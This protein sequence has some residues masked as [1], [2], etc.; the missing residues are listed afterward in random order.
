MGYKQR[1]CP[2][3]NSD[4]HRGDAKQVTCSR[5]C[6]QRLR[7][8]RSGKL[9][10]MRRVCEVCGD[11]Y[12]YSYS[13]QRT[14]SRE[15]GAKI[16]SVSDAAM[17]ARREALRAR[18]KRWPQC[19]VWF[20]KCAQCGELFAARIGSRRVC[21]DACRLARRVVHWA[22]D[23]RRPPADFIRRCDDCSVPIARARRKCDG[24]VEANRRRQRRQ[25][26]AKRRGVVSEPYTLKQ[27][28]ERDRFKCGLCGRKVPM[29]LTVPHPKA[30]TIDHSL[31]IAVG[32]DDTKANVQ[33]AHFMCNSIK[34]ANGSQQLALLG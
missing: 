10:G 23:K 5:S 20:I 14:C 15:C 33:L 25:N 28:A 31:P 1:V 18:R 3:C 34:G 26:E 12:R 29:N 13:K 32:G 11:I 21:S 2:V 9:P 6:A 30:P 7:A 8:E 24:C 17:E 16:H 22:T 4:F 19:R 27:V